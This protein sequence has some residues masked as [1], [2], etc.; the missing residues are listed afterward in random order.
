M[1]VIGFSIFYAIYILKYILLFISNVYM[2]LYFQAYDWWKGD[3]VR[4]KMPI[5]SY[6]IKTALFFLTVRNTGLLELNEEY[7]EAKALRDALDHVEGQVEIKR[8]KLEF[9]PHPKWTSDE[10]LHQHGEEARVWAC[11]IFSLIKHLAEEGWKLNNYWN[12]EEPVVG[13]MG[14]KRKGFGEAEFICDV[15]D[16]AL[17]HL[18]KNKF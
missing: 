7:E 4:V 3:S 17:Y 16:C 11:K 12:R 15:C 5:T 6:T 1:V 13:I 8:N 2:F 18:K 9:N 10:D 14:Y